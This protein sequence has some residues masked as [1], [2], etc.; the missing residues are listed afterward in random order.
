MGRESGVDPLT[1]AASWLV[2]PVI[3]Q[4]TRCGEARHG[5]SPE[6]LG[7]PGRAGFQPFDE[8]AERPRG[9]QRNAAT[10]DQSPVRGAYL[11]YDNRARPAVQQDV[12]PRPHDAATS[13]LESENVDTH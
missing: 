4:G 2:R 10:A 3:G 11:I 8:V 13:R 1:P 6:L 12:M 9:R 5:A 7:G